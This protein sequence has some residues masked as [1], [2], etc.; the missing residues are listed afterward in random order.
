MCIIWS[1]CRLKNPKTKKTTKVTESSDIKPDKKKGIG[2]GVQ[3]I[4]EEKKPNITADQKFAEVTKTTTKKKDVTGIE[5]TNKTD[6]GDDDNTLL[7]NE[8]EESVPLNP[9]EQ[10]TDQDAVSS[11]LSLRE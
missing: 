6:V 3:R 9:I 10:V 7:S 2:S 5:A 1:L 11:S 8:V 4:Y